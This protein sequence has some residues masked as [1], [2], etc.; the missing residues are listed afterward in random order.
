MA[1]LR[2]LGLEE[3]AGEFLEDGIHD[4]GNI[5]SLEWGSYIGFTNF[6]V[7]FEGTQEVRHL[8][9]SPMTPT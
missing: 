7:W 6:D 9:T 5:L 8:P 2:D 1:I 3:L 4:P